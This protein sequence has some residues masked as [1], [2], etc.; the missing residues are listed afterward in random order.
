MLQSYPTAYEQAWCMVADGELTD[1]TEERYEDLNTI[2][3]VLKL[4]FRLLPIPL[5]TFDIYFKVIDT[6]RKCPPKIMAI[7]TKGCHSNNDY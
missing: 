2:T 7:L 5:V 4:Y 1:I 6:I 3:S